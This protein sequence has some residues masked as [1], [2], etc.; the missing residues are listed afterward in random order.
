MTSSELSVKMK[1]GTNDRV[2]F[3]VAYDEIVMDFVT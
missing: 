3:E 1:E 2:I